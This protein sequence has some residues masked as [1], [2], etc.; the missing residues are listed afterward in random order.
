[1]EKFGYLVCDSCSP[2]EFLYIHPS[3]FLNIIDCV[4]NVVLRKDISDK[5]IVYFKILNNSE[6]VQYIHN[7]AQEECFGFCQLHRTDPN[8]KFKVFSPNKHLFVNLLDCVLE[9]RDITSDE[10]RKKLKRGFVEEEEEYPNV[11]PK[12]SVKKGKPQNI[13][14]LDL[15][16]P[17]SGSHEQLDVILLAEVFTS[18]RQKCLQ[19]YKLDPCHFI[20]AADLTWNAG[21]KYIKVELELFSD[22]NMYLWIENSIRGGICFVGKRYALANNPFIPGFNKH[23]EESYI[24]AVDAN[25]L[26]GY[27]MSQPLPI[28]H[29]FWLTKDEVRNLD[30]FTLSSTDTVG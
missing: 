9:A 29:F 7:D 10:D 5:R 14:D 23:E 22:I 24:I 13:F 26:Y 17:S 25:N 16:P 8:D 1:M 11:S 27:A 15:S 20:T 28:G 2:G 6:I 18:F 21:L 4:Q 12:K 19:F 30:V 3:L